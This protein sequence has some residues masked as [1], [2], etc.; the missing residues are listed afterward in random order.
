MH[1]PGVLVMS[2]NFR[3]RARRRHVGRL[4]CSG[5]AIRQLRMGK[6]EFKVGLG[7]TVHLQRNHVSAEA[8]NGMHHVEHPTQPTR[9]PY[10]PALALEQVISH[11]ID[12]I[13]A[14]AAGGYEF[15]SV[16]GSTNGKK[17]SDAGTVPNATKH[18]PSNEF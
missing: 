4:C 14:V 10:K 6:I 1:H 3:K 18:V 15:D 11:I 7:S 5:P 13:S 8:E 16:K 17:T 9:E 2:A 12:D